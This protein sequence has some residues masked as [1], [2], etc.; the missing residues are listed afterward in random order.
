MI[1]K[2]VSKIQSTSL[3]DA[4][5]KHENK[6]KLCDTNNFEVIKSSLI[7]QNSK[8][9]NQMNNIKPLNISVSYLKKIYL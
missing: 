1:K 8:L 5:K 6:E 9:N 2:N 7:C 3:E 4:N